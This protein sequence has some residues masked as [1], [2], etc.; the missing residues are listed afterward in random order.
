MLALLDPPAQPELRDRVAEQEADADHQDAEDERQPQHADD[1]EQEAE[2]Q[3][4]HDRRDDLDAE[5]VGDPE[6]AGIAG[7]GEPLL[8]PLLE[9][10]ARDPRHPAGQGRGDRTEG[11]LE[12]GRLELQLLEVL[13]LHRA[14]LGQPGL[15][16]VDRRAAG[17]P[18]GDQQDGPRRGGGDK[19]R[20]E[21]GHLA[22]PRCRR[23]GG[24][25]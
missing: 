4:A 6:V 20:D 9:R 8:R 25:T 24:S 21:G 5:P 16:G 18:E 15:H 7:E 12:E 1:E 13:R 19:D 10:A 14:Q 17:E 2:E 23:C 11:P 22:R 3:R